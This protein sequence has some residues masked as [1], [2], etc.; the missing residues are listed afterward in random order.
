[1]AVKMGLP[2]APLFMRPSGAAM[3]R[4]AVGKLVAGHFRGRYGLG[5]RASAVGARRAM[6]DVLET[7]P[8]LQQGPL[9]E[10]ERPG[11]RARRRAGV[12]GRAEGR[13]ARIG[14]AIPVNGRR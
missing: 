13:S 5:R 3:S 8:N 14:Q 7:N 4:H 11:A 9:R 1:M 2:L 12:P 6:V 10:G